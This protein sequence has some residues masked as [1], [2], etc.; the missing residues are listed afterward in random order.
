MRLFHSSRNVRARDVAF[1]G[2]WLLVGASALVAGWLGWLAT[3]PGG[4]RDS[5]AIVG[6][7]GVVGIAAGLTDALRLKAFLVVGGLAGAVLVLY[8]AALIL[9]GTEDVGGPLVAWPLGA[10]G[11]GLG[12]WTLFRA[13][14]IRSRLGKVA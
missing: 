7:F 13:F 1:D 5:F 14:G 4:A 2:I 3:T 8:C 11:I 10:C 6:G 9:L 12:L